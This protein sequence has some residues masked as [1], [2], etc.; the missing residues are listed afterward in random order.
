MIESS[1]E[2]SQ[3]LANSRRWLHCKSQSSHVIK[4][5]LGTLKYLISSK[6]FPVC[7]FKQEAQDG[8]VT[9]CI[10]GP[11]LRQLMKS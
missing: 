5:T 10:P 3:F 9:L 2:P 8:L 7:L 11:M 1:D 6:L 4:I